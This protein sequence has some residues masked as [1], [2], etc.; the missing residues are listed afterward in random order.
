[1]SCIAAIL[2]NLV[3]AFFEHQTAH[4]TIFYRYFRIEYVLIIQYKYVF[5]RAFF[6]LFFHICLNLF[7]TRDRLVCSYL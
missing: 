4:Y 7:S 3:Y 1:M 2:L 5:A 6:F